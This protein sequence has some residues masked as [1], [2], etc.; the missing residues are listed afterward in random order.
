MAHAHAHNDDSQLYYIEQLF[1]VG[2]CGAL[3]AVAVLLWWQDKLKFIVATPFHPY[4]LGGGIVLLILVAI[5]AASLWQAADRVRAAQA[6]DHNHDHDHDHHHHH[7]DHHDHHHHHDHDHHDHHHD[8]DHDHDHGHEHAHAAEGHDHGSNPWRYIVLMLPV[9][10]YFLNLPNQGFSATYLK[11]LGVADVEAGK[12]ELVEG[13]KVD[14]IPLEFKEL[15][16]AA[17]TP[18]TRQGYE[19]KYASIKGQFMPGNSDKMFSLYRFKMTC[20]AADAVPL[21]V[22]IMLDPNSVETISDLK[23]LDWVDVTGKIQFRK[24]KD[25]EEYV[26]VLLVPSRDKIRATNP[27]PNP[28][29]Q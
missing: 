11:G 4:V 20:C 24:R 27:D 25:R 28:Y 5:R 18:A 1:M 26:S 3:G 12:F 6:H 17:Y 10:L 14:V 16:R 2:I 29:L 15:E 21:N 22:L 19:G 7:H 23:P 9:V 13:E 8:H